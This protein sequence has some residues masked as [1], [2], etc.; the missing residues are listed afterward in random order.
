MQRVI[1]VMVEAGAVEVELEDAGLKLRV[2]LKGDMPMPMMSYAAPAPVLGAAPAAGA[3]AAAAPAA[4]APA[5]DDPR[6][7]VFQ[8]PMVGTFYRSSS[9]DSDPFVGVGDRVGPDQTICI[10]EAMKVMNEIK[11]EMSGEIVEVLVENGEP[12]EFGQPLFVI[13]AD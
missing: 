3:A 7:K 8:S 4:A 10:L 2:R 6:R 5:A 12:V 9:P 1:D 13:K 11:A